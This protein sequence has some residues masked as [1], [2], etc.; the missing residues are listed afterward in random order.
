MAFKQISPELAKFLNKPLDPSLI[1]KNY[2]GE[3]YI[4]GYT[5]VRMLNDFTNCAWDF[6]IDKT[7]TEECKDKKGTHTIYHMDI[8]L[9]CYFDDGNGNTVKLSKP[10]TAGKDLSASAKNAE[11]I[12]KSLETLALRKAA[13]YFGIGAE[14]WLNE[15]EQEYFNQEEP[16]WTDE[17]L[18]KHAADWDKLAGIQASAE[19]SDEDVDS[20]V[21]EWDKS[22]S[23]IEE[24]AP[25]V[26]KDF[27]GFLE[28]QIGTSDKDTEDAVA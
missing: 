2:G 8:T 25:E 23:S 21:T 5:V 22:L 3:K 9:N 6:T 13:S 19:L 1:R 28:E 10:G 15:D 20:L 17:L 18:Q 16:L 12:Y 7:W 24:V 14:L 27:I 26:F 4:T 11:N